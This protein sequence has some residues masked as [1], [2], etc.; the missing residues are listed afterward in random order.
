MTEKPMT[1][2]DSDKLGAMRAKIER[3]DDMLRDLTKAVVNHSVAVLADDE[4][5][6]EVQGVRVEYM[7]TLTLTD[8]ENLAAVVTCDVL[9]NILSKY[10][11]NWIESIMEDMPHEPLSDAD[12]EE[13]YM[14]ERGMQKSN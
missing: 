11:P 12:M 9:G 3:A 5:T 7:E 1:L 14:H 8:I 10:D 6:V 4:G 2:I 13:M